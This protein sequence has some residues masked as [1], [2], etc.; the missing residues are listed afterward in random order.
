MMTTKTL[1]HRGYVR[2]YPLWPAAR[3]E[4]EL[5]AAGIKAK[6][7]YVEGRGV[8]TFEGCVFALYP[9]QVLGLF[10]GLRVLGTSRREIMAHL[11][12]LEAQGAVALDIETNERSDRQGAQMLH[13]ALMRIHGEKTIGTRERASEMG[14]KG[15]IA[16]L[17]TRRNG[18]MSIIKA[19]KLWFDQSISRAQFEELT[20]WSKETAHREFGAS[21]RPRGAF[22][23]Q[24][25]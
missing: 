19:R 13:K 4:K 7:V 22:R 15:A 9:G 14:K 23:G 25:K 10:G 20:G 11:G 12:T 18:R 21:G 16:S 24:A 3:Q 2:G 6:F 5:T 17:V 8:E 1:I